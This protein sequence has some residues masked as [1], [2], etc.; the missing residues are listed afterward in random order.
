MKNDEL[1]NNSWQAIGQPLGSDREAV[2][3]LDLQL[4]FSSF[5]YI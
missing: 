2:V 5:V 1:V 3:F 4:T